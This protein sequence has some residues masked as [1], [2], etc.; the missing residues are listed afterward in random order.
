[1][2]FSVPYLAEMKRAC[3]SKIE[4]YRTCLDKNGAKPDD[5]VQAEC[6]P[7]LKELWECTDAQKKKVDEAAK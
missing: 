7:A 4:A 5:V 3:F 1:M 2:T 6:G